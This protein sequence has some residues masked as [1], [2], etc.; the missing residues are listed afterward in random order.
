[1]S[2]P[3]CFSHSTPLKSSQRTG[4]SKPSATA[5]EERS[6]MN[7]PKPYCNFVNDYLL[8]WERA[9]ILTQRIKQDGSLQDVL[10]G[11]IPKQAEMK[12]YEPLTRLFN[13]IAG[14]ISNEL[15]PKGEPMVFYLSHNLPP[16]G[17]S[18][19]EDH[20]LKPDLH[21]LPPKDV[22][23]KVTRFDKDKNLR[24]PWST[25][26]S[27]V[28]VKVEDNWDHRQAI[29]YLETLLQYRPDK[30]YALGMQ[31]N[32][33]S[34]C[35]Y[36]GDACI[37]RMSPNFSWK[38]DLNELVLF[39]Y[40]LRYGYQEQ[41]GRDKTY[42]LHDINW[43]DIKATPTW[44]ISS[45]PS[46]TNEVR[47]MFARKGKT[48]RRTWLGIGRELSHST[49]LTAVAS[50]SKIRIVKDM[51]R[52]ERRRFVECELL[53]LIHEEV[54]VP[55]VVRHIRAEPVEK[56]TVYDTEDGSRIKD[57]V[58]LASTGLRLSA[59]ESVL[60]FLKVMYDLVETHEQVLNRGVLHRDLSWFNVLC[61]PEHFITNGQDN[62]KHPTISKSQ[63][64]KHPTIAELLDKSGGVNDPLCLL[65]DFD[66]ACRTEG[67]VPTGAT[68][69]TGTPMFMA[70]ELLYGQKVY[71]M[72]YTD[73]VPPVNSNQ[74]DL[75][76]DVLEA[77]LRVYGQTR[78]DAYNEDL[79]SYLSG[80]KESEGIHP[81]VAGDFS[82]SHQP[83]HDME[84]VYW[85]IIWFLTKAWPTG[86]DPDLGT[87]GRNSHSTLRRTMLDREANT[88][89]DDAMT[90]LRKSREGWKMTLHAA[91]EGLSEML[92]GMGQY[93]CMR[94]SRF[95]NIF[96]LHCHEAFKR[97][98]LKQIFR[99]TV[100]D[101]PIPIQ[102]PRPPPLIVTDKEK[103]SD[104][105]GTSRQSRKSQKRRSS[106]LVES[107]PPHKKQRRRRQLTT[108]EVA[109]EEDG[110]E[111]LETE[112]NFV[113]EDPIAEDETAS[114]ENALVDKFRDN[115]ANDGKW[116]L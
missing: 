72:L 44:H 48:G 1:M 91:Y 86:F 100:E 65:T 93:L 3:H 62:N 42:T 31:C 113:P 46:T 7:I 83:H 50:K 115:L 94:W 82:L 25:L 78:Y 66:N 11:L 32:Q 74:F 95:P 13:T 47:P 96:P 98:L 10:G 20:S 63:G 89:P 24:I 75:E 40:S 19:Q 70:C 6:R 105:P 101:K 43:Q 52:D 28:E 59:C 111:E 51:W 8:P 103:R 99:M 67:K 45:N 4:D 80:V 9:P 92:S 18:R 29:D 34:Y 37:Q 68:E 55:G 116:F 41:V 23:T 33:N 15:D 22:F 110:A 87:F 5:T 88:D 112:E 30:I 77:Y 26:E 85:I 107:G 60:E 79:I 14:M 58:I 2:S 114:A 97:L 16:A 84:S 73:P 81:Y 49:P 69:R 57:R 104:K 64:S 17:Q 21:I 56:L 61:K 39:I 54:F 53:D 109:S 38:E 108:R 90:L 27:F 35:F 71:E 106:T 102:G 12:M 36:Y 76:G